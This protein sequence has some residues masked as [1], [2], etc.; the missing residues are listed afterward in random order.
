M[1]ASGGR[2]TGLMRYVSKKIFLWSTV[3]LVLAF[4]VIQLVPYGRDHANPPV[5]LEPPWDSQATRDL[6]VQACF[7][8]HSNQVV[9]PW[10]SNIAPVSWWVQD[11]VDEGRSK[12]NFSAW[13]RNQEE[14]HESA[15]SVLD[16]EMPPNYYK[17]WS[18]LSPSEVDALVVGLEATLG[19]TRS[20]G[21]RRHSDDDDDD[22]D[23]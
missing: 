11:H 8:C 20:G 22:D 15:E 19:D 13:D 12:L 21:D 18:R 14:A 3:A 9:W 2:K 16:G 1:H 5:T 7:D 10:Y 23:G 6:A 17:P 4:A